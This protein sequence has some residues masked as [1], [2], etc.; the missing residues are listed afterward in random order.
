MESNRNMWGSVKS[1]VYR[2][3]MVNY[4]AQVAG[5]QDASILPLLHR[6]FCV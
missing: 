1:S 2:V 3:A 6:E 5:I 4:I